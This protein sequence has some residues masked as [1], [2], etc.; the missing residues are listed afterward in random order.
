MQTIRA[1]TKSQGHLPNNTH[2]F[3][4]SLDTN[5]RLLTVS[6]ATGGPDKDADECDASTGKAGDDAETDDRDDDEL[7]LRLSAGGGKADTLAATAGDAARPA[8][9]L[10]LPLPLLV[11][12]SVRFSAGA[13]AV[14]LDALRLTLRLPSSSSSSSLSSSSSSSSLSSSMPPR[15]AAAACPLAAVASQSS[16]ASVADPSAFI[17]YLNCRRCLRSRS[18]AARSS[19]CVS[20]SRPYSARADAVRRRGG[21]TDCLEPATEDEAEEAEDEDDASE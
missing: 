9:L 16:A 8:A 5:A 21:G 11:L 1:H 6:T 15:A 14:D 4:P 2:P 13:L 10:D 20:S 3:A 18:M 17:L 19:F 7:L 12:L